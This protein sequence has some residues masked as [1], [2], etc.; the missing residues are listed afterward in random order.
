MRKH[1]IIA[2]VF[3]WSTAAAVIVDT[4]IHGVTGRRTWITDD[5][6][7]S[8]AGGLASG[9]WMAATF[10]SLYAVL[11]AEGHR[12]AGTPKAARAARRVLLVCL[13]LLALGVGVIS[14]VMDAVGITSGTAYDASGTLA[15][16]TVVTFSLSALVLSVSIGRRN[17]LGLGGLV[18]RLLIPVA[19]ATGLL[20]LVAPSGWASPAYCSVVTVVG[21]TLIGV[22]VT[23]DRVAAGPTYHGRSSRLRRSAATGV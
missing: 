1:H 19:L 3:G 9:L 4:V 5:A 22:R 17:P 10:L 2:A 16:V 7:A 11:R 23:Q 14:T 20:A 15:F 12:F 8:F 13:P 6:N 18:L 21:L